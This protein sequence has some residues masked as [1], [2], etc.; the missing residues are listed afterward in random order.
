MAPGFPPI[1]PSPGRCSPSALGGPVRAA[2]ICG[3]SG[4]AAPRGRPLTGH[5]AEVDAVAFAP[6][7]PTRAAASNDRTV[8]LRELVGLDAL[9]ADPMVRAGFLSGGGLAAD[10]WARVVPDLGLCGLLRRMT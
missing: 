4:P 5:T 6:D 9:R 10:E 8:Q 2:V 3:R 1:N 7:G